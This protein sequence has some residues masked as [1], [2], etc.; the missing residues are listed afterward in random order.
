MINERARERANA[1]LL[2]DRRKRARVDE[3]RERAISN[4]RWRKARLS[5]PK[6]AAVFIFFRVD[7]RAELFFCFQQSRSAFQRSQSMRHAEAARSMYLN[8]VSFDKSL[9]TDCKRGAPIWVIDAPFFARLQRPLVI[10]TLACRRFSPP[11]S[12]RSS[13][14]TAAALPFGFFRRVPASARVNTI[15]TV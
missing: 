12:C 15:A 7:A 6:A 2:V 11:K 8:C 5:S 4:L 10:K 13:T 14:A 9:P 1:R 3:R